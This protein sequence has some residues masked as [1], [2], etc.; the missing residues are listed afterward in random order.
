M[1]HILTKL[2]KRPWCLT[3]MAYAWCAMVWESYGNWG[4]L[5]TF[6]LE[7]GFRH[8]D[9]HD[10]WIRAD[11][12]HMAYHQE[13]VEAVFESHDGEVIADFLQALTM[14]D[15]SGNPAR[16]S[17]GI[18][19]RY[20]THL[21]DNIGL[22]FSPRLRRLVIRSI[23]LTGY[24]G[25]E[26]VGSR[27]C[28]ELLNR[29]RIG[30]EDM[31]WPNEWTSILLKAIQSSEGVPRLAV[32]SWELLAELTTEY[33]RTLEDRTTYS[34]LVTASLLDAKEWDKLECWI[35]VLWMAW[36]SETNDM[37][38]D[39]RHAADTLFGQRPGAVQ[40]LSRWMER[41][42]ED[43]GKAIP[44]SFQRLREEMQLNTM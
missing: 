42:S 2:E 18:C 4:G 40:K 20:I 31:D 41:W 6:P 8:L 7:I 15:S 27:E 32:H 17:L 29:L 14:K 19:T 9:P 10:R 12:T 30:V 28:I 13:L 36:P 1:L 23:A 39:L 25:F 44:T 37:T 34:P 5:C 16:T 21:H 35:G 26:E 22:P 11:L 3:E 24:E 43:T 38:G 33:S